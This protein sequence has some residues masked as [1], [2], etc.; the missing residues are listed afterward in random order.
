[1]IDIAEIFRLLNDWRGLPNYQ[2][3]RR[4]D[5]LFALYLPVIIEKRFNK[6]ITHD[7]IVPEFPLKHIKTLKIGKRSIQPN[8]V[9]Y[10]VFC[11]D[12]LYLIELKTDLKSLK[13]K[14]NKFLL[15][16]KKLSLFE[17]ANDITEL[18]AASSEKRKYMHL[19]KRLAKALWKSYKVKI[20]FDT[21]T[22]NTTKQDFVTLAKAVAAIE[23][24]NIKKEVVYILPNR[25][26]DKTKELEKQCNVIITFSEIAGWLNECD[27]HF[28][29]ALIEW[30]EE[31]HRK[32]SERLPHIA[33]T[34]HLPHNS[35]II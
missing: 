20:D 21:E 33:Q 30:S 14:Q 24:P 23:M 17:L 8:Y 32:L 27:K 26:S 18:G 16:A 7:N 19:A 25:V 9:D 15:D 22:C 31:P 12:A 4:A 6:I 35:E 1:M 10:V 5:I 29:T 11:D 28:S 3:E 2:L 13:P 34:E